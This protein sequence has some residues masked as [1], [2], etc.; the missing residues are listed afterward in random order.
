MRKYKW[1]VIII[2]LLVIASFLLHYI[3]YC[4]F[5]DL[6]HLTIYGLGDLAFL[7]LD[8]LIVTFILHRLLEWRDKKTHTAKIYMIIGTYFNQLGN[9]TLRQVACADKNTQKQN[10][11]VNTDWSNRD[12]NQINKL[13]SSYVPQLDINKIDLNLLKHTC[14][15]SK[16]FISTM[17]QNP[18]LLEHRSFT[19]L[20]LASS[21]LIEELEY[22]KSLSNLPENDLKHLLNDIQ[23]VYTNLLL[24]WINYARHLKNNYTYLYSLAVRLNPMDKN[25][26]VRVKD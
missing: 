1:E 5:Q 15:S 3:H 22:R 11:T 9:E 8:V 16:G 6:T 21:H 19:D 13:H 24:E 20:L 2:L 7:P 26:D 17:L 18:I 4:I 10:F 12:F 23:R 25:L 14:I